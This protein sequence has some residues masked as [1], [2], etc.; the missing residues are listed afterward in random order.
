MLK[1]KQ[2]A[3]KKVKLIIMI[4]AGQKKNSIKY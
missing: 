1:L 4:L 3:I 2:L